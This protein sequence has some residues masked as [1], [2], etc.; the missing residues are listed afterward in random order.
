MMP[1][2]LILL[3]LLSTATALTTNVSQLKQQSMRRKPILR[4]NNNNKYCVNTFA[5]RQHQTKQR[6]F[7]NVQLGLTITDFSSSLLN[8]DSLLYNV[9]NVASRLASISL[10]EGDPSNLLTSLP[11]MYG[12][13]LLTSASPCVWGLLPLTMSYISQAAGERADHKTTLPSL[14]FAAGLATVFCTLGVAA[15]EVGGI[16]G[17]TANGAGNGGILLSVLS[18]SI[19][20]IMGLKLLDLVNIRLPSFARD[21]IRFFTNAASSSGSIATLS[22]GNSGQQDLILI[23]GTG[24]IMTADDRKKVSKTNKDDEAIRKENGSLFRTFLLGGSSALVASPCASKFFFHKNKTTIIIFKVCSL[25]C[26]LL[27][28]NNRNSTR[29]DVNISICCI[30]IQSW[31]RCTT[32]ISL[33]RWLFHTLVNRCCYWWTSIRKST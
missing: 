15:V 18:S 4:N 14:A 28:V 8:W 2:K 10:K 19:C 29:L 23:D 13:G 1:M 3:I 5:S 6:S 12:A 7:T 17:S 16:F 26:M 32:I 9:Q 31:I 30:G 20:L 27:V 25:S 33:Y 21:T 11:I 24:R 22:S